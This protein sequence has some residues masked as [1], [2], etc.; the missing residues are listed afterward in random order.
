VKEPTVVPRAEFESYY[1]RPVLHEPAWGAPAVPGYLFLGGL[2]GA[3]SVLAASA[4][5]PPL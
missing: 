2:A 3:S 5:V 4:Q 1:G